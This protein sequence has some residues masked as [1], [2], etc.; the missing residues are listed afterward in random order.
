ML[1]PIPVKLIDVNVAEAAGWLNLI[2]NCREVHHEDQLS[3]SSGNRTEC[4]CT[5]D[6]SIRYVATGDRSFV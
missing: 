1:R 4:A 2:E 5:R 6:Q 3:R